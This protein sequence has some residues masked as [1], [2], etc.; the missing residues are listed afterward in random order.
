MP[1]RKSKHLPKF[2]RYSKEEVEQLIVKL[3][4][5]GRTQSEIG[6]ILRDTYGI[7]SV[8]LYGL[9]IGKVLEKHGL[10]KPIPEDLYN[11][12]KQAVR[13]YNHLQRHKKDK[14]GRHRLQLV[15]DEIRALVKYYKRVGKLPK[16]WEY[17]IERA[18]LI[19]K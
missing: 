13:M 5:E 10:E 4:K 2:V 9:K 14:Y 11:L 7:P 1:G 8:K 16:D 12:L 6:L 18:K 17:D 3:A 15:E 19:V